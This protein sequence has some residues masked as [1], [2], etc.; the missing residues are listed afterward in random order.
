VEL[1]GSNYIDVFKIDCGKRAK[2]ASRIWHGYTRGTLYPLA[3]FKWSCICVYHLGEGHV[4]TE[5]ASERRPDVEAF[6][7]FRGPS[8]P[9]VHAEL[10]MLYPINYDIALI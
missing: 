10:N 4:D 3:R 8:I 1:T 2:T 5:S 9:F 7:N 6:E